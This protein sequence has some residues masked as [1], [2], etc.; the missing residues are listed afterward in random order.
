MSTATL[1]SKGQ[2]TIP[3]AVRSALGL[4]T[5][6]RIEFVETGSGQFAIVA[7]TSPIQALKGVLRKPN[8]PVTLDDMESAIIGQGMRG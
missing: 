2:V 1:S 6:S 8:K 7:A 5:G 4:D 3:V